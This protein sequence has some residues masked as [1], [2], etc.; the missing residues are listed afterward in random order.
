MS[1]EEIIFINFTVLQIANF[2]L[3][4]AK[5]LCETAVGYASMSLNEEIQIP[6]RKTLGILQ[7]CCI[8]TYMKH[9]E[10]IF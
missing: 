8:K 4:N 3:T 5:P 7:S 1:S 6:L 9:A 2:V 10:P